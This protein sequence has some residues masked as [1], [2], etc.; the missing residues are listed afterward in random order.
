MQKMAND[1]G[2]GEKVE[3]DNVPYLV[4]SNNFSKPGKGQAFNSI[5][6]KKISDGRVIER[7]FKST[8][9]L[10]IADVED[11]ELRLLYCDSDAA[12]F[13]DDK[14]F[15]QMT[16]PF[17]I[18]GEKKVWLKSDL[19]YRIVLYDG[20]PINI[21]PPIFINLEVT[22]AEEA[23]RG[24]TVGAVMKRVVVETGM[25]IEVPGFIDKGDIIKVDTRSAS[26]SAR[27]K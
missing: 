17:S 10:L 8:E 19:V 6:L 5:R 24:N 15:D 1:I 7:N 9:K 16:I 12:I 3:I 27:V 11:L 14:S 18:I 21:V 26:Y 22:E 25:K 20:V 23:V 13:M 2:A 4:V